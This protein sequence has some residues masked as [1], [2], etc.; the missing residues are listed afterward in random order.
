MKYEFNASDYIRLQ[1]ACY[2]GPNDLPLPAD[3][4]VRRHI[5]ALREWIEA[6][7]ERV[8]TLERKVKTLT[9]KQD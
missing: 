3:V 1:K 8:A 4:K 5:G 6:L 2:K 9:K 7:E